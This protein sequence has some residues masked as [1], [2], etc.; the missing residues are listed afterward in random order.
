MEIPEGSIFYTPEQQEEYR[1]RKQLEEERRIKASMLAMQKDELGRFYFASTENYFSGISPA[2]LA[3]LVY[4]CTYLR[5]DSGLL[6]STKRTP[7]RESDLTEVLGLSRNTVTAFVN[8]ASTFFHVLD[9]GKLS[10][11]PDV[12]YKGSLPKVK[13]TSFQRTKQEPV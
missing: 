2:T 6:Y 4:L 12:F 1:K 9:D 10:I 13:H 3:R 5:Y 8:E 11:D 7:M